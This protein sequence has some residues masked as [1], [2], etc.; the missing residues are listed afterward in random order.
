VR[1]R[2]AEEGGEEVCSMK[3]RFETLTPR[4]AAAGRARVCACGAGRPAGGKTFAP[5]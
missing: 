2:V 4:A 3:N 5:L 1:A